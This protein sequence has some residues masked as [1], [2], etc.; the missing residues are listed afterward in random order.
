MSG[1]RALI[2]TRIANMTVTHPEQVEKICTKC[3]HVVAVYPTGQ[4]ALAQ[5]PDTPIVCSVCIDPFD[6]E[7]EIFSAGSAEET[8]QEYH[9]SK[10]VGKA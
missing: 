6:E 10:P 1:P 5:W 7:A 9:E 8:L 3:G 4:R 2:C